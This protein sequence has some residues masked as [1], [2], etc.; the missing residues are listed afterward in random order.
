[1]SKLAIE[2]ISASVRSSI[3]GAAARLLAVASTDARTPADD[4]S[5]TIGPSTTKCSSDRVV[6]G[7]IVI[8]F[9]YAWK[10]PS[11]PTSESGLSKLST[12]QSPAKVIAPVK[13]LAGVLGVPMTVACGPPTRSVP[14]SGVAT[15]THASAAVTTA[16]P[17]DVLTIALDLFPAAPMPDCPP[18]ATLIVSGAFVVLVKLSSQRPQFAPLL[19][20]IVL[21]ILTPPRSI[22]CVV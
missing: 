8:V 15:S 10:F 20:M 3:A 19:M 1:M 5:L 12:S 18:N 6:S 13:G 11:W 17:L 21:K 2:Q 14:A 22:D 9:T 4:A 16:S 7:S